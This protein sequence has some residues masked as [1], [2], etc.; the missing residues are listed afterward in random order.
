MRRPRRRLI[1]I[2][3][4]AATA[5]VVGGSLFCRW[6]AAG[7]GACW[8]AAACRGGLHGRRRLLHHRWL[9]LGA[10]GR[11]RAAG[12]R[13][14][15]GGAGCAVALVVDRAGAARLGQRRRALR[16]HPL[17]RRQPGGGAGRRPHHRPGAPARLVAGIHRLRA[18][19]RLRPPRPDRDAP[20]PPAAGAAPTSAGGSSSSTRPA[21]PSSWPPRS[22]PSSAPRPA[23]SWRS[24]IA[25]WATFAGAACFAVAGAMQEFE[26]P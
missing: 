15:W 24:G 8:G 26:R 14:G 2:N 9:R 3:A 10:A 13:S 23:T 20:R 16:R 12:G 4:V 19:P 7:A 5:F 25:N 17:L 18:L 1:R 22:P 21:R 6:G 11:Q